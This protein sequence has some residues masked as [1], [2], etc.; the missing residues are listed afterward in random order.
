MSGR[1]H[2]YH[3]TVIQIT[4]GDV[5]VL[6]I[7]DTIVER[8]ES[9]PGENSGCIR[10]IKPSFRQRLFPFG[11][12]ETDLHHSLLAPSRRRHVMRLSLSCQLH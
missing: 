12:I 9:A 1:P 6:T 4:I 5:A 2:Q 10:K 11:G 8:R 3:R 7:V